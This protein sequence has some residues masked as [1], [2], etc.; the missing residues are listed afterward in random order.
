MF[1]VYVNVRFNQLVD[2]RWME[3][4]TAKKGAK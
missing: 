2:S 1:L 4:D 3:V